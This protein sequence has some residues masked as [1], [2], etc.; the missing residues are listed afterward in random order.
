MKLA[1]AQMRMIEDMERNL[2]ESVRYMKAAKKA[3]ADLIL[4]PEVQL[5][6]FFAQKEKQDASRWLVNLDGP[7]IG[8]LR[9][10]CRKLELWA[11]PNVYLNMNGRNY[12]A[13]LMIDSRGEIAGVS[14]MVHIFQA[15]HFYERDYYTP[16]PDGLHVYDTPFGKIGIVICFDRHVPTSIRACAGKG[17]ELILVPTANLTEEPMELFAWEIRVQAF[18][19]QC[20]IAMCNRV[21]KEGNLTFAGESLAAA[22]DGSLLY[23][24]DEEEQ[25]CL[26]EIP[27]ETVMACRKDRDWL[28][29]E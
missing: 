6:P 20:C 5:S 12:D 17:A 23:A 2:K 3:G 29:F 1:M 18:Q 9:E 14:R 24:A 7:E 25:L 28:Q 27:V 10:T 16:S 13:S 8:L 15:K 21:G 22:P 4:F 26:A 11:S 19:N